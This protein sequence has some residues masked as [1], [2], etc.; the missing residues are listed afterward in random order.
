M[1]Q[2]KKR[3]NRHVYHWINSAYSRQVATLD[4]T[5]SQWY[6][7]QKPEPEMRDTLVSERETKVIAPRTN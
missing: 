7:R 3:Q 4:S 2:F 6:T 1:L 5:S